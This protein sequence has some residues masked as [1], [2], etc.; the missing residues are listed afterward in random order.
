MAV[1]KSGATSD[2]LT[3]DPTSKAARAT[4]YDTQGNPNPT[5]P[6]ALKTA[7]TVSGV[8]AY[9]MTDVAGV[10]AASNVFMSLFNPIGSGKLFAVKRLEMQSY[11]IA[12]TGVKSSKRFSRV[13]AASGGTLASSVE[14]HDTNY[15]TQKAEVR[16]SNPSVSQVADIKAFAP[17][18][19]ISAAS[20][21]YPAPEIEFNP[22]D[23]FEEIIL[24]EGQGISIYQTVA[25][26]V[27]ETM[28]I[29]IVWM[30]YT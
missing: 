13:S 18:I 12:V 1:I 17:A 15:P 30:E 25:G 19:E 21:A 6:V 5:V 2:Q 16:I 3:V 22:R 9:C 11:T 14:S 29:N 27:N 26:N 24:R 4:L 20:G 8:Y 7:R 23:E 28:N 10:T